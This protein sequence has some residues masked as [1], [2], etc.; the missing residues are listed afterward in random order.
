MFLET[1]ISREEGK[2]ECSLANKASDLSRK[3]RVVQYFYQRTVSVTAM[4]FY[5]IFPERVSCSLL[6]GTS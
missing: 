5:F 1:H 3:Q 4:T 6:P 2:K